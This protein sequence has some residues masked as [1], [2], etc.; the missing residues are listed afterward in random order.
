[1]IARDGH[2]RRL[3]TISG[4][5]V[6]AAL[7]ALPMASLGAHDADLTATLELPEGGIEFG[8]ETGTVHFF[9]EENAPFAVQVIDGCAIN[10]HYWV[11]G[12]GL[13]SV[14]APL[15]VFDERTGRSHRLVLPA[16]RPGGPSVSSSTPRH[17]RSPAKAR[18]AGFR[19]SGARPPT[20]RSRRVVPM[21]APPSSCSP[22]GP[23]TRTAPSN[24]TG[25]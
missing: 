9:D 8:L 11:L 10:G 18:S 12:A 15:T 14:A 22:M 25:R 24:V 3:L 6:L 20:R 13:G 5:G 1:M 21:T 7:L 4:A 16:F 17:W 23:R 2:R 19:R